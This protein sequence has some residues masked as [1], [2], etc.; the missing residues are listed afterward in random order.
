MKDATITAFWAN[1]V[2]EAIVAL[3]NRRDPEIKFGGI[4]RSQPCPFGELVDMDT[5]GFTRGIRGGILH[6]GDKNYNVPPR[7]INLEVNGDWL[8]FLEI[9]CESNRDDDESV[10]LPGILTSS[11]VNPADFWENSSWSAG[12]PPTQY[13]DNT[14]P[15]IA[16][17]IGTIIVPV[18]KLTVSA[19]VARLEPARCGNLIIGQ[20]AGTLSYDT[21]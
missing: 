17:G 2:R 4:T 7:G 21:A 1:R 18:G 19:G 3:A 14:H 16:D 8:I 9:V 10:F 11:V 13:P 20:C 12:P 6:V 15:D 5:G